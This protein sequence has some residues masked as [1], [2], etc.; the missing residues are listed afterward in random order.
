VL[1]FWRNPVFFV[2]I[3]RETGEI[4]VEGFD[5]NLSFILLACEGQKG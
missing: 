1:L 3:E 4:T 2:E 5:A